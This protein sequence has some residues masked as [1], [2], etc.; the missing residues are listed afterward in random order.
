ML[1]K[2]KYG[3]GVYAF[4]ETT[5]VLERGTDEEIKRMKARYWAQYRKQ[6]KKNKRC[7]SKTV[8]IQLTFKEQKVIAK[9]AEQQCQSVAR[10][11]KNAALS[12]NQRY[13]SPEIVGEIRASLI[14]HYNSIQTLTEDNVVSS[15]IGQKLMHQ[16][17][18]IE[19]KILQVVKP[20][21]AV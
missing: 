7:L 14:G 10:F 17:E 2:N 16:A 18:I 13:I 19:R 5:G 4:L 20:N 15:E 9:L 6:W 8:E 3:S 11:I 21:R 1:R 12:S